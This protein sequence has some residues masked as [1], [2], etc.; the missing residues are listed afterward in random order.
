MSDAQSAVIAAVIAAV[1]SLAVTFGTRAL[2]A[3]QRKRQARSQ[4]REKLDRYR[5]PLL[6]AVDNLGSRI[7]N[8]R[9]DRFLLYLDSEDRGRTALLGTLFRFAQFFGWTEIIYGY[10]DRMRFES[11]TATKVVTDLLKNISRML[12]TDRLDRTDTSDFTSTQLMIWRE[13]QRAI[14]EAMRAESDEPECVGFDSFYRNYEMLYKDWFETFASQLNAHETPRSQRMAE[15]QALLAQLARKLDIDGLL[16]SVDAEDIV[17]EPR[18]ARP[19]MFAS[20]VDEVTQG[21]R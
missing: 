10:S 20:A 18:W 19:G 1:V 3:R 8:I 4:A 6:A 9:N 5:S 12:A 16:V 14:G 15:L 21:E 7:N 17:V 11:D 13:E 2:D